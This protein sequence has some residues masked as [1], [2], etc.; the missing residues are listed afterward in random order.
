LLTKKNEISHD[1]FKSQT[2]MKIME[3]GFHMTIKKTDYSHMKQNQP[4]I[5]AGAGIA[6]L[7]CAHYLKKAGKKVLV[8]EKDSVIGGRVQSIKKDGFTFD[9]GF[10]VFLTQYP[11]A[12]KLLDYKALDLKFFA[13]G[14]YLFSSELPLHLIADPRR[15]P[16]SSISTL[17]SSAGSLNDKVKVLNLAFSLQKKSINQIFEEPEV[18]TA[19]YLKKLGFS[20]KFIKHFFQPFFAGI[21]LESQLKT[22]CRMFQFVFKMFTE[23]K[24]A[25]PADG[26]AEIPKQIAAILNE[27]EIKLNT[28]ISAVSEG[29]IILSTGENIE[30][31]YFVDA[32][33]RLYQTNTSAKPY[34]LNL[35]FSAKASPFKVGAIA[36]NS[37]KNRLVNN[38]IELSKVSANYAPTGEK[39]ISVSLSDS[40]KTFDDSLVE[41]VKMELSPFVNGVKDWFY[42]H[43]FMVEN[44]LPNQEKIQNRESFIKQRDN[45]YVIGDSVLY[46]SLNAA[47][48]SGREV[49]EAILR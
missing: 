22:S 6:G 18:S 14:A 17:F 19:D 34:T 28:E 25:I 44:A 27:N 23:G 8:I 7:T 13:P 40:V 37:S 39:L 33:N 29:K 3:G 26:I 35:Y 41:K 9:K 16:T 21:F 24:A 47:M 48:Q 42:L 4:I 10:Q 30:F 12:Q 31:E 2:P 49:A 36:L 15:V 45:I 46:G 1:W 38:L 5:I 43:Q 20:S 32:T 11:E